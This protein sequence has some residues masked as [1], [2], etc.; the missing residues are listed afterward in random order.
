[1]QRH[2]LVPAL[3]LF[4]CTDRP[5]LETADSTASTTGESTSAAPTSDPPTGTTTPATDTP[6]TDTNPTDTSTTD[7]STT[8]AG[9]TGPGTTATTTTATTST[10][11]T[12]GTTTDLTATD[13]GSSSTGEPPQPGVC[14]PCE[15]LTVLDGPMLIDPTT[16]IAQF[17]CVGTV[18]GAVSIAGDLTAEQLAPLCHLTVVGSALSIKNN[19]VLTDLSPFAAVEKVKTLTLFGLPAL[20]AVSGMTALEEAGDIDI[21]Q[22]GAKAL[23][24]FSPQFT[25]ITHLD[26]SGNPALSDISAMVQWGLGDSFQS[27]VIQ[28]SPGLKDLS[29]IADLF[30][31]ADHDFSFTLH[32]APGMTSLAGL[33]SAAGGTYEF[34][35]LP[36]VTDLQPLAQVKTLGSLSLRN[37]PLTSLAGLGSLQSARLTLQKMPKLTSLEGL[38]SLATGDVFLWDLPVL[39]SLAGLE[40]F[41]SGGLTFIDLPLVT[42]LAPLSGLVDGKSVHMQGMPLVTSLAGLDNLE[43]A[44]SLSIGDCV[45]EG[46]SGMDG[47]T[48]LAGL[49]ALTT[50]GE[51]MVT[52]SKK[53]TSLAG[54]GAL[55]VVSERLAIINN[56]KLPKAAFDGLLAQ[57]AEPPLTCFGDWGVCDCIEI[58]PP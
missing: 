34:A 29:G 15:T 2:H 18:M 8:D 13:T 19:T 37:I 52:N 36:L 47:L 49:G 35:D 17:G 10:D 28:N 1:M 38:G 42:S 45:N 33:G 25:G 41:T 56:P 5:A 11:T 40:K 58:T 7:T 23:G 20:T 22:T 26:I 53:L 21:G 12:D 51:F 4:A 6:A 30:A 32:G 55:T 39:A 57:V 43:T 16:D 27:I 54:V 9:T 3:L 46:T 24:T 31:A 50:A 48:S 14:S 44:L